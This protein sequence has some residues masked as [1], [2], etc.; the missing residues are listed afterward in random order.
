MKPKHNT[1]H[2]PES[3]NEPQQ[4]PSTP[5]KKPYH[6]P[7]LHSEPLFEAQALESTGKTE[8]DFIQDP[9][10]PCQSPFGNS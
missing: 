1:S 4:P 7:T 8:Q 6:P 3:R 5:K 9:F 2:T 10:G